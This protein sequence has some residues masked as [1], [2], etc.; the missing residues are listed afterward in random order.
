MLRRYAPRSG[1]PSPSRHARSDVACYVEACNSDVTL[2][3]KQTIGQ[4]HECAAVLNRLSDTLITTGMTFGPRWRD[5]LLPS[6]V[7]R[8]AASFPLRGGLLYLDLPSPPDHPPPTPFDSRYTF[9]NPSPRLDRELSEATREVIPT[10]VALGNQGE[11]S[12]GYIQ[13]FF[14]R[15]PPEPFFRPNGSS[16]PRG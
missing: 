3:P 8:A 11:D 13:N 6:V 12:G 10:V 5:S 15:L 9:P 14:E 16:H 7:S 1:L 4:L 2:T